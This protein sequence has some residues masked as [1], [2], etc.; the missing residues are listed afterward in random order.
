MT[1]LTKWKYFL[2]K[3][4]IKDCK[5]N[6]REISENNKMINLLFYNLMQN[7]I[8]INQNRISVL[9]FHYDQSLLTVK[10]KKLT[11]ILIYTNYQ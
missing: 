2:L 9:I 11:K 1:W 10:E 8:K 5:S 4:Q 7:I 3:L 6:N